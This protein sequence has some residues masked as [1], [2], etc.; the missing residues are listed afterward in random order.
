MSASD[1]QNAFCQIG[2]GHSAVVLYFELSECGVPCPFS[3]LLHV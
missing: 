1:M 3:Y 2:H